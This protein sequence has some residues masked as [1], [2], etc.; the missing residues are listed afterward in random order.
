MPSWRVHTRLHVAG[1]LLFSRHRFLGRRRLQLVQGEGVIEESQA[2]LAE[3]V[4]HLLVGLPRHAAA[5]LGEVLCCPGFFGVGLDEALVHAHQCVHHPAVG[6]VV[7]VRVVGRRHEVALGKV[8]GEQSACD[9]AQLGLIDASLAVVEQGAEQQLH[10]EIGAHA[11]HVLA[12]GLEVLRPEA[13]EGALRVVDALEHGQQPHPHVV[14]EHNLHHVR[15]LVVAL[16][17]RRCTLIGGLHEE[18]ARGAV[19]S[20]HAHGATVVENAV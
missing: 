19:A 6:L 15:L 8:L 14:A 3:L 2:A 10:V 7:L 4:V 5:E 11:L 16:G 17:M 13:L 9:I 20:S 12:D 18:C 1:P